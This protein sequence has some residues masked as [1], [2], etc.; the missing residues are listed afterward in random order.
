MRMRGR[1]TKCL[2][3]SIASLPLWE[4]AGSSFRF[5]PEQVVRHVAVLS[6][7]NITVQTDSPPSPHEQASGALMMSRTHPPKKP[8]FHPVEA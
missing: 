3:F 7:P 1:A 4:F 6:S 8:D 2:D 5:E